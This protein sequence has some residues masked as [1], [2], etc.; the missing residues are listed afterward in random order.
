MRNLRAGA[1]DH[2]DQLEGQT[3]LSP[4]EKLGVSVTNAFAWMGVHW[5][6]SLVSLSALGAFV[7]RY[8]TH[9]SPKRVSAGI[10]PSFKAVPTTSDYHKD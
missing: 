1:L 9:H 7:Y 8:L 2:L 3:V 10:L 4:H 6:F 5:I